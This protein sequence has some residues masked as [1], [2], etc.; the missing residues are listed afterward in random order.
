[1]KNTTPGKKRPT[2]EKTGFKKKSEINR[3]TL[4]NIQDKPRCITPSREQTTISNDLN[5]NSKPKSKEKEKIKEKLNK[6]INKVSKSETNLPEIPQIK[7]KK[8]SK[9]NSQ[10]TFDL[11]K[12]L[13]ENIKNKDILCKDP[14]TEDSFY[15]INCKVST[16]SLCPNFNEHKD[17][18]LINRYNYYKNNEI[19]VNENFKD[20]D[21]IFNMNPEYLN[22]NS[23]RGELK[24]L[25][26]SKIK[27]LVDSL[28]TIKKDK[29]NE[30]DNIFNG[31]E[32]SVKTLK[33]NEM[34]IKNDLINYFK[35]QKIF[36]NIKLDTSLV[37]QEMNEVAQN[38][39]PEN[40][41][42]N[43]LPKINNNDYCN[44][45]FLQ[46]YD[47]LNLSTKQNKEIRNAIMM[48]KENCAK[49]SEIFNEKIQLVKNE[50]DKLN[51]AFKLIINY[52]A[53][54][55]DYYN[56][57]NT[58]IK[59]YNE[60]IKNIKDLVF[61][62]SNKTGQLE[63]IEKLNKIFQA[64]TK[65]NFDN[66]LK[67]QIIENGDLLTITSN[68]TKKSRIRNYDKKG[69][70]NSKS[71]TTTIIKDNN[72]I[73][74]KPEIKFNSI[75][76]ITLS[77][78]ILQK[79]Y[80]FQTLE[81]INKNFKNQKN[82]KY[83]ITEIKEIEFDEDNDLA[84][85]ISGTNEI[86]IYDKKT[87]SLIK[88]KV[89]YDKTKLKF[90]YF[91]NGCRNVL[92]KDRLYITGGVDKENKQLKNCYVYYI[93]TNELKQMPE[94]INPR[95]YHSMEFVEYF[96]SI[97]VIGGE[98]NKTCELYDMYNSKWRN[99]PELNYPRAHSCIYLDRINNILYSLFGIVGA[100][101]EKNINYTDI[102]ECLEL[103]K[104]ALGWGKVNYNNKTEMDFKNC[105]CRIFPINYDMV[106]VYGANGA[107]ENKKRSAIFAV[108]KQEM[109][110]ISSNMFNEIRD[111]AKN[112]KELRKIIQ[113]YV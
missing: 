75:D 48:I 16:C 61:E 6:E 77:Y 84:K 12:H 63:E 23:I 38:L 69:T 90:L 109:I 8:D 89:N 53:L 99:L 1:M 49:Y 111:K 96:K 86:Q 80:A 41:N 42:K 44:T 21:D 45:C 98:N 17:H 7:E 112:S 27:L 64:K 76:D 51:E 22:V 108:N 85:P 91:Y 57:I 81:L 20:L 37:N 66:I 34:K 93:K 72:S 10:S 73:T 102:I 19:L 103:K 65:Q 26:D 13:K 56:E 110:K 92:I 88:K 30:I 106:L 11:Y 32:N 62:S 35:T 2:T 82:N 50:I 78:N 18:T 15:C 59:K 14:L 101:S 60:Q 104:M 36:S 95:A 54:S 67:N 87:R 105:L 3:T 79:Y 24:I 107:R 74:E 100:I 47:L 28:N 68:I 9:I 25:V 113:S 83:Q 70:L 46:I 94:M 40:K 43:E 4:K 71:K 55:E 33:N 29:L 58:K 31:S 39:N 97:I 5:K 52:K